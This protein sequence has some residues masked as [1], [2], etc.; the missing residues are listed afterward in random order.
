MI[1]VSC[2]SAIL[3]KQVQFACGRWQSGALHGAGEETHTGD[4]TF[5][6]YHLNRSFWGNSLILVS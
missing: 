4:Y 1:E 5:G 3:S 2:A 6:M